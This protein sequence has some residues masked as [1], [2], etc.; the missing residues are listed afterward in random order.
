MAIVIMG[1]LSFYTAK[2]A[3][4][5]RTYEQLTSL[6][7]LKKN[8]VETFFRDRFRDNRLIANSADIQDIL[9]GVNN[10]FLSKN[11]SSG[12]FWL[13]FSRNRYLSR[14][15][16]ACGYYNTFFICNTNGNGLST[17]TSKETDSIILYSSTIASSPLNRLWEKIKK[18]R[19]NEIEDFDAHLPGTHGIYTGSP[20]FDSKNRLCGMVALEISPK[21]INT[22][23]VEKNTP[24]GLGQTGE[25][26]LVGSDS[27]IRNDSRFRVHSTFKTKVK[28]V[29]AVKALAGKRGTEIIQ[30]YRNIKVLSSYDGLNIPGLHWVILAEIDYAEAFIPIYKIRNQTLGISLAI[31]IILFLF[32]FFFSR[33]IT[34]PIIK[35]KEAATRIGRGEYDSP[36]EIK[37]KNEIGA[38]TESFNRMTEQLKAKDEELRMERLKRMRSVFDGHEQERQR[39]SRELHDGLG[40]LLI[41]IKLK[42]EALIHTDRSKF[43]YVINQVKDMFD[44]TIDEIRSMSNDLMPAVLNEFGLVTAL[45]NLCDE[46][47]ERH[48]IKISFDSDKISD[49]LSKKAKTYLYRIAQEALINIAKHAE[50]REASVQLIRNEDFIQLLIQDD[51]KGF[52]FGERNSDTGNGIH[53]MRERTSLLNGVFTIKSDPGKGT[54]ISIKIPVKKLEQEKA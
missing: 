42:L 41:A 2:N 39:I 8:Q 25:T 18:S 7:V 16:N 12:N 17:S 54:S 11:K 4:M 52:T 26:Y 14:Y 28:S 15:L 40:Q 48:K 27:L 34:Q 38:L 19:H 53:N 50:A 35:L 9:A 21:A 1:T 31:A 51:G 32:V 47:S 49:N 24:N 36:L 23:M 22:I 45:R 44:Q 33:K 37:E 5:N 13:T 10:H 30:D 20:V 29:A 43:I 6:R 3:L 46:I